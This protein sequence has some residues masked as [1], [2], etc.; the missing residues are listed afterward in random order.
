MAT[1]RHFKDL[2]AWQQCREVRMAIRALVKNWPAEE[3]YRLVDQIIR[4]SRGPTA[5]ISEGYGRFYEKENIRYCRT[6]R[7]SLYE[8]QDHLITACDDGIITEQIMQ[9]H[10][11]QVEQAITTVNGY[12][13]Y[14]KGLS[15]SKGGG[16]AEPTTKYGMPKSST[17]ESPGPENPLEADI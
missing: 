17:T 12:I 9:T 8:T 6:A 1:I 14:L 4:S 3:K 16:V 15:V 7:G 2:R 10:F 11:D 5:H 13:K